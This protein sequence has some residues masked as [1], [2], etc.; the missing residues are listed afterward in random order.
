MALIHTQYKGKYKSQ[1][2]FYLLLYTDRTYVRTSGADCCLL[3][4]KYRY[5][6]SFCVMK[7]DVKIEKYQHNGVKYP[8]M[9]MFTENCIPNLDR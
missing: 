9:V 3:D 6:D 8:Q 7:C 5:L 1:Y 4:L 2:P